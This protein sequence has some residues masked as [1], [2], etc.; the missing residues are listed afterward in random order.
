MA[1]GGKVTAKDVLNQNSDAD[2]FQYNGFIYSNMTDVEWFKNE[3]EK[4][5]KQN[6]IGEIEKQSTSSKRF[7]DFTATKLP[8]GTKIYSTN[9][10]EKEFGI[11]IV[12]YEGKDL[13]YMVLLEG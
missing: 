8:I 5:V 13:Y 6:L 1:D 7:K 12:E 4:Y 10:N 3:K 9:K 2:I 11:L